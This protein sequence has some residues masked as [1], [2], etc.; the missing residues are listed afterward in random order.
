MVLYGRNCHWYD[1]LEL[2]LLRNIEK[3]APMG[4]NEEKGTDGAEKETER[5]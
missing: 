1:S 2:Y 5:A 3:D 4:Y